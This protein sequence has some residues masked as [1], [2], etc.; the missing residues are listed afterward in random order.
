MTNDIKYANSLAE[1]LYYL[2]GIKKR[3]HKKI[4]I[5]FMPKYPS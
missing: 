4:P 2:Q 1:V 3:I 5:S